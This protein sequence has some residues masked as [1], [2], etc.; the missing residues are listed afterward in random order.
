MPRK[1]YRQFC[2][3][4]RALDRLG[5][6]WTLLIVRNLLLGPRRYSD[7]VSELPGITTNLLAKRLRELEEAGVVD[8]QQL[9]SPNSVSV[10]RLTDVGRALEPVILELGR[11]GSR[12]MTVPQ[13]GDTVNLGW[14]FLSLKRRYRGGQSFTVLVEAGEHRFTLELSERYLKVE[15]RATER[16]DLCLRGDEATILSLF[17]KGVPR[18]QLLES[19]K[20]WSSGPKSLERAL[21]RAF[22][23]P[24]PPAIADA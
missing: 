20:L 8:K 6:R 16:A 17:F 9:P 24:R 14:A 18:E 7:L 5:E 15:E 2:G 22:E 23:P 4:A 19:G 1:S 13:R 21:E 10:Y 11:W 3:V 12:F